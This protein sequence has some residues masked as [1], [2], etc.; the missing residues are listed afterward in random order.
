MS[1]ER[2]IRWLLVVVMPPL[3]VLHRGCGLTLLVTLLTIFGWFP[4]MI[5][6]AL[7]ML[8]DEHERASEL[9]RFVRVPTARYPEKRKHEDA[10]VRLADGE[11]AQVADDDGELPD[12][13][14]KPKRDQRTR[15]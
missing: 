7:V 1:G 3:A 10:W 12:A 8:Y 6:A 5:V 15:Q 13:W 4:G 2:I 14:E 9:P 11:V